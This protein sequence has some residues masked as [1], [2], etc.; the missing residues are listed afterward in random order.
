MT[1]VDHFCEGNQL[2]QSDPIFSDEK[3]IHILLSWNIVI[4]KTRYVDN[5][6][7]IQNW[8]P[9]NNIAK[10]DIIIKNNDGSYDLVFLRNGTKEDYQK[11]FQY[12]WWEFWKST[13]GTKNLPPEF[14][15]LSNK[16]DICSDTVKDLGSLW[17]ERVR[18]KML[19][20]FVEAGKTNVLNSLNVK[21]EGTQIKL[22][23]LLETLAN[24][25][26]KDLIKK[27]QVILDIVR[28]MT[29]KKKVSRNEA[30]ISL[31]IPTEFIVEWETFCISNMYLLNIALEYLWVESYGL[32]WWSNDGMFKHTML[33]FQYN[34]K[35]FVVDWRKEK[36]IEVKQND[37]IAFDKSNG[38][39]RYVIS[40]NKWMIIERYQ[41]WNVEDIFLAQNLFNF[42]LLTYEL[43]YLLQ[44][45]KIFP[46]W[47][48]I[49]YR[50]ARHYY[51]IMN[52]EKWDGV[53]QKQ[54]IQKIWIHAQKVKE[55]NPYYM[56][57]KVTE[58][59]KLVSK[60]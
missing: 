46:E 57:D 33:W 20:G 11:Y 18:K 58:M 37:D 28:W 23:T 17:R 51:W 15:I 13:F 60:D 54:A 16:V 2:D 39:Y 56:T 35:R 44:A 43:R 41:Q 4:K 29:T 10:W 30:F 6:S 9:H 38:L 55:I 53:I 14:S 36:V 25:Q 5:I 19:I 45:H 32:S 1:N 21:Y 22:T 34:D 3:F 49:N 50:L 59:L 27:V 48:R 31:W 8:D 47:F 52:A 42:S 7:Q 26:S 12:F 24:D 40:T